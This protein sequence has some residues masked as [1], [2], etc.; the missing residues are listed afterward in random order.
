VA[1]V[2]G[3]SVVVVSAVVVVVMASVD[4]VVDAIEVE[5]L[6]ASS[7]GVEEQDAARRSTPTING[8]LRVLI[9]I[10]SSSHSA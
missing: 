9:F 8:M 4:V 1:V 2:V 5:V 10:P 6:A 3:A 7:A